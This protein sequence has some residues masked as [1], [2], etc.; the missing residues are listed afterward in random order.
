M[1]VGRFCL[2]CLCVFE[3]VAE[4]GFGDQV[5]RIGWFGRRRCRQQWSSESWSWLFQQSH[6]QPSLSDLRARHFRSPTA[7]DGETPG[8][9][10][11][12]CVVREAAA[13]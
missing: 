4:A 11:S 7:S 9:T 5:P 3:A 8:P 13:E 6:V 2:T 10:G 12:E 1:S